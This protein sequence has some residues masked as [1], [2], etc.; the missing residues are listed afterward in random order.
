MSWAEAISYC[1][2]FDMELLSFQ[3]LREIEAVAAMQSKFSS[4]LPH[5]S[6]VSGMT[7]ESKSKDS[8]YW[9]HSGEKIP[10]TIQWLA[11][12]PNDVDG[13]EKCLSVYFGGSSAFNDFQCS[14]NYNVD[15]LSF[16]CQKIESTGDTCE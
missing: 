1:K 8:W 11:E 9:V 10:F 5:G 15:Y 4:W 12:E 7:D 14:H 16:I 2:A 13:K 3:S 6:Y